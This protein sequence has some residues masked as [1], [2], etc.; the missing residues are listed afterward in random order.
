MAQ[1]QSFKSH[2]RWDPLFHFIIL[3]I[4][5]ANIILCIVFYIQHRPMLSYTGIWL[6]VLSIV[7]F[8]VAGKSR[9]NALKVQDRVIRLEERTRLSSMIPAEQMAELDSLDMRQYVGLRFA[10]NPE[11]PALARRAVREKLTEKQ[12]KEAIVSWRADNDRV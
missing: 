4:L 5:L 7:I 3:P 1:P 12:I 2:T 9:G 6:I 11:L 10:S 8:M